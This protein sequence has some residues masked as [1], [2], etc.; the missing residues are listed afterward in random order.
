MLEFRSVFD[1]SMGIDGPL[2]YVLGETLPGTRACTW[3]T[4]MGDLLKV[5]RYCREARIG[6]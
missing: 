3:W 2:P 4:M 5:M 1:K 6:C